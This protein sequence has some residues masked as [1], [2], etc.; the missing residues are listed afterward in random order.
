MRTAVQ[1]QATLRGIYAGNFVE[2]GRLDPKSPDPVAPR[3]GYDPQVRMWPPTSTPLV[4]TITISCPE[5]YVLFQADPQTWE[6]G[7]PP[8]PIASA[9]RTPFALI[10]SSDFE[11][12]AVIADNNDVF[13]TY[14]SWDVAATD[15]FDLRLAR[16]HLLRQPWRPQRAKPSG[17]PPA[18]SQRWQSR[19]SNPSQGLTAPDEGAGSEEG[20]GTPTQASASASAIAQL[21]SEAGL[22]SRL[23]SNWKADDSSAGGGEEPVGPAPGED[24]LNQVSSNLSC[25]SSS[26]AGPGSN[27]TVFK[28]RRCPSCSR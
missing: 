2:D 1:S 7:L 23:P 14:L 15:S 10:K 27:D 17:P 13:E 5:S 3:R 18:P 24:Q 16:F 12:S 4:A 22:G 8:R 26:I 9:P 28:L 19:L 21:H 20:G 6:A 11:F 25:H